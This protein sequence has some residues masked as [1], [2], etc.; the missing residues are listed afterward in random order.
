MH[1]FSS[2][3][4]ELNSNVRIDPNLVRS[5]IDLSTHIALDRFIVILLS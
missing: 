3:Q 2:S 1:A 5:V 4:H